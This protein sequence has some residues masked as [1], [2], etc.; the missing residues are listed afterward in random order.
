MAADAGVSFGVV[1]AGII[2]M[3]TGWLW[4]DPVVSLLVVAVILA[5]TWSLLRDSMNLA[6][7][8]VPEHIDMAGIKEHLIGLEKV[9]RIHDLHVWSISTTEVALTVHL[10]TSEDVI[11]DQSFLHGPQKQLHDR[12]DIDHSTIQVEREGGGNSCL[13]DK[14]ECE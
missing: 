8:A 12:F 6:I 5:G 14:R 1:A 11:N 10:T 13:L 4:V 2:M 7:D 3:T 9:I